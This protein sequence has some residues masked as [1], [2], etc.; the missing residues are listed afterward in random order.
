MVVK[1]SDLLTS[2]LNK[3]L[4]KIILKVTI[5]IHTIKQ[6]IELFHKILMN[7]LHEISLYDHVLHSY[8]KLKMTYKEQVNELMLVKQLNQ[9][10][11]YK[12]QLI[13]KS[14][15]LYEDK[16]KMIDENVQV[17]YLNFE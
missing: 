5:S 11:S 2:L 7:N 10:E 13:R 9:V 14:D 3:Y 4:I 8:L 17:N 16:R 1:L 15:D 6:D 12:L